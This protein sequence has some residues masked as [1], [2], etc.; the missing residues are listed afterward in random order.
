MRCGVARLKPGRLSEVDPDLGVI[1]HSIFNS[2][3]LECALCSVMQLCGF[4]EEH[5]WTGLFAVGLM[6]SKEVLPAPLVSICEFGHHSFGAA[7]PS[8]VIFWK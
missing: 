2:Y 6:S 7:V 5:F 3:H 1:V 8:V 4:G